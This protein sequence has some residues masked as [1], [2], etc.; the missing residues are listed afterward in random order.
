[1]PTSDEMTTQP[2]S[3]FGRAPSV[4]ATGPGQTRNE[5]LIAAE[6]E[7]HLHGFQAASLSQILQDA[8]VTKGA[9]YHHFG[10][11]KALGY[12]VVDEIWGPQLR[13]MW[14][15][16]LRADG[17]HPVETMIAMIEEAAG[18]ITEEE[19]MLGCPINN[20]AQEMSP[21]DE[22]FRDRVNG[23]LAEWRYALGD[24]LEKG[25][26][27]GKVTDRI[28]ATA[29]AAMIVASLE[30]CIGVAKNAQSKAFLMQCGS[31]VIDYLQ[32]LRMD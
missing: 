14:I 22:G 27:Q 29:A 20:M 30:G 25:Q 11:K 28:D 10:S 15:E 1:M 3:L 19:L 9:L 7:M 8:G 6:R 23:L 5:I 4:V 12:A 16:P 26:Q 13:S 18:C 24:A 17:V 31:G 21:I 32:T 2:K